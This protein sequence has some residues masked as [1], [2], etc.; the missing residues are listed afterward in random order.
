ME[1][2]NV[3]PT[4]FEKLW[5]VNPLAFSQLSIIVKERLLLE[6]NTQIAALQAQLDDGEGGDG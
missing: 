5:V 3:I 2:L 6:A 1:S 4:D